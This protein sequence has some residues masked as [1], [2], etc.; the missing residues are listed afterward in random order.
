MKKLA[1]VLAGIL[2]VLAPTAIGYRLGTGHWPLMQSAMTA[3][4]MAVE[5]RLP[6]IMSAAK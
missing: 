1:Y 3:D 2:A 5:W 6:Q 4:D